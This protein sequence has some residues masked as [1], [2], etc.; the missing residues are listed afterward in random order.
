MEEEEEAED[1][2]LLDDGEEN[3]NDHAMHEEMEKQDKLDHPID[4]ENKK[5]K[6]YDDDI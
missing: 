6:L 5:N 2:W 1:Q 4:Q 3:I